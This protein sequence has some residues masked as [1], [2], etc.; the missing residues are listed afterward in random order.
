MKYAL[1]EKRRDGCKVVE[2]IVVVVC[3]MEGSKR[4]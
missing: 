3:I 2:L 4:F 1:W